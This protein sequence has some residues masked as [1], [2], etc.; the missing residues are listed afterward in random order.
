MEWDMERENISV[1]KFRLYEDKQQWITKVR[2]SH[3]SSEKT[4]QYEFTNN[5]HLNIPFSR[6]KNAISSTK[7]K[8]KIPTKY[9]LK[10]TLFVNLCLIYCVINN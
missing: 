4:V 8:K 9:S 2:R 3:I 1:I 7:K 5:L 10:T 6:P